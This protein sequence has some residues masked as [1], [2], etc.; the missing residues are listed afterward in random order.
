MTAFSSPTTPAGTESPNLNPEAHPAALSY[1]DSDSSRQ[2]LLTDGERE[3]HIKDCA[4]LMEDAM[5]R[6]Y[7]TGCFS[8][9]GE[10]DRWRLLMEEAIRGRSAEVVARMEKERRLA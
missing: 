5:R 4:W 6:Y 2:T 3:K 9:R 7:E 8:H 1:P 10:A